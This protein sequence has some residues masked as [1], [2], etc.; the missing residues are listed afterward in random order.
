MRRLFKIGADRHDSGPVRFIWHP[1]GNFIASAGRN[2]IVQIT[3]RHGEI[4]D[5]VP[6]N[7][8]API[9]SLSWDKDG[10]FLAILQEGN[11]VVPLFNLS[12]RR[13]L[14]LETGLKD[15]TFI[16]WSK[17]GPQLAVGTSKGNLL[18]YNKSK[19]QKIPVIGKHGK[20]ITCGAWALG[21]NKL[22][23]G[24]DD[25]TLT[26]S[27]ENGDTLIHA[28]LTNLPTEVL[29]THRQS[30]SNDIITGTFGV[31]N[32]ISA[33]MD[34]KSIL[35]HNIVDEG[36]DPMELTFAQ[37]DNGSGCKY[38][39][40]LQHSWVD[41]NLLLVGF[42]SGTLLLV[43]TGE[44]DLG[45]E[46]F[47]IRFHNNSLIAFSYNPILK[48]FAS[49]GDDGVRIVD[50]KDFKE[51]EGDFIS[52]KDLEDG[53][54][55]SLSWSPDGQ[56]LTVSTLSGPITISPDGEIELVP[57]KFDIIP[58]YL[59]ILSVGGMITCQSISEV[60][61]IIAN[62]IDMK[63]YW[64]S[65]SGK[66]MELLDIDLAIKVYRQL[67]D[68]GKDLF[69]SS[70]YPMAALEMR[71]DL[72]QW[73]QAL[74]LAEALQLSSEIP[75][76]CIQYGQIL[77]FKHDIELAL[78]IYENAVQLDSTNTIALSGIARC[79]LKANQYDKAALIYTKYLI[80]QD[81]SKIKEAASIMNKV[82]NDSLNSSF[83]RLCITAGNYI[84]A[85]KAY[86]RA[87]DI[88]K[89]VELKLRN[90]DQIQEA[91]DIA[92]QSAT[93]QGAQ[94]V[95]D[96]CIETK[97]FRGAIEFLLIANKSEDAF[98]LAITNN[99][100]DI[101]TS[102]IQDTISADD[103]EKIANYYE[104]QQDFGKAG[105]YY[106][107]C[108]KYA[109]ALSL[110][111][112]CGDREID[113]AIAVVGK[114][115]NEKLIHQLIDFLVGEKDGVPKD[116]N[117]IYRLHMALKKYEDAAK[118]ALIIARQEQD[119]GNYSLAHSVISEIIRHLEDNNIRVSLQIRQLFILLHSYILVKIFVKHNDHV[120]A[121]RLLLRVAQNISK[122]PQHM[123]P[124]LIST[125]IECQR[126]G[127]KKS[128]YEYAVM[129]M[130]P[131][132][133]LSIDVNI[134]RKIEMI[135]RRKSSIVDETPEDLSPDPI[136]NQL[137]PCTQ[138]ESP[139]TRD[140][141]P[142]CIITG[143]HLVLDDWCFC[144]NSKFP[145]LYSEYLK[146]IER[147]I[148]LQSKLLSGDNTDN[149]PQTNGSLIV[150]DP[151]INKPITV[152]D[153]KLC[154]KDEA[155]A[156]IQKYNDIKSKEND[157]N[158][159]KEDANA[160]GNRTNSEDTDVST[161]KSKSNSKNDANSKSTNSKDMRNRRER[162]KRAA[163]NALIGGKMIE[164]KEI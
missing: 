144:P 96:Y 161:N 82:Q 117:Y 25:R 64:L 124:I 140:A 48:R 155:L 55:N 67:G 18:I 35:L 116:P 139:V 34:G 23:L 11:G 95:A 10:E 54:V 46:K 111:I 16:Q 85:M 65:L 89:V 81:K 62:E 24:S 160:V 39:D 60:A 53:K 30:K 98:K 45:E 105:R 164:D 58:G 43:S 29:F 44:K 73:D 156:Y 159:A 41:E 118:T 19:K 121:A 61:W 120:N 135:V 5:E 76:I 69:L 86:E 3:D 49:A 7:V 152:N 88:D 136:S 14:P 141:I 142:M 163:A 1:E 109:K 148:A 38:G 125:V 130:R 147:E 100:M 126:G 146:Y 59:P 150:N 122:F 8:A 13:L 94:V 70:S 31:D 26:V 32:T 83:A 143:K 123:I 108:G 103:A 2:G 157:A 15:P 91:F 50:I 20:R 68:A 78:K 40:I 158:A 113:E 84:E 114:S 154:T 37:V 138:L 33:I 107:I 47:A 128:S 102:F 137:I 133:R 127:L 115:Q 97:D 80:K 4:V 104:K 106:S 27:D 42:S 52:R 129:L 92:R 87:K 57:D 151:V 56:I 36:E 131:E 21:T 9:L 66:A 90:L 162:S 112:Q 110:F 22:A 119:L 28:E 12:T 74:K 101:Y 145:A 93:S 99:L 72:L 79:S 153:L 6:M 71:K 132:H 75:Y 149:Q 63:Q 51:S 17:T 77:E 134:R